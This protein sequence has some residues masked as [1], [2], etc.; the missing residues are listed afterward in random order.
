MGISGSQ[1]ALMFAQGGIARGGATRGGYMSGLVFVTINGQHF[2]FG[3]ETLGGFGILYDTLTVDDILNDAPNTCRF[4]V[5]HKSQ[6]AYITPGM[7]V[8]VQLGSKNNLQ[9]LFAGHI[10]SSRRRVTGQPT[11]APH[12]VEDVNCIDDTW[13]AGFVLVTEQYRGQS[14]TAIAQDLIAKYG[15]PDGFG[16][17]YVQTGLPILDEITFTNEPLSA[18]LMRLAKRAGLSWYIDAYKQVHLFTD[19]TTNGKPSP[20]TPT[21]KTMADF[22]FENDESQ[23]IARVYLEGRGTRVLAD[24]PAGYA[25]IPVEAV[26]MFEVASDV[27]L[28]V[29][30]QGS[31]GGSQ[32]LTFTG[33]SDST[34]G[35]LVGPGVKPSAAPAGTMARGGSIDVGAHQYAYTWVTASGETAPSPIVTLTTGALTTPPTAPTLRNDKETSA[36]DPSQSFIWDR[37]D[38]VQV[39]YSYAMSNS[40]SLDIGMMGPAATI[41]TTGFKYNST[42][43]AAI[44][45]TIVGGMAPYLALWHRVNA[46]TWYCWSPSGFSSPGNGVAR[47]VWLDNPAFHVLG[48]VT[49]P[50]SNPTYQTANLTGIAVG[51]TGVTARKVYRTAAGSSQLKL[52]TTLANNTAT[53]YTDAAADSMLG[54]NA[55][56]NDTSGIVGAEGQV[57]PGSTSM[58]VAST[59][60]ADPSGGWAL[61]G[62]GL[63]FKYYGVSLGSLVG[64]NASG[65]GSLTAAVEY[66][67]TITAAPMLTGVSGLVRPLVA[68]D[69][70]YLVVRADNSWVIQNLAS[71][72]GG[73]GYRDE[74]VQDRRLSITECRQ[75]ASA[76][77]TSRPLGNYTVTYR[78]RDLLT[79]SGKTVDIDFRGHPI[80]LHIPD[81]RIQQVTI[82]NFRPYPRQLPTYQVSATSNRYSFEDLLRRAEYRE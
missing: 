27:T 73:R 74:W 4:S 76:T 36:G 55:P 78:C 37:N 49:P 30:H 14:S 82:S 56:T 7:A 63:A 8:V 44:I 71:Q 2:A 21:H 46:G 57:N 47:D 17:T 31:T 77:L 41:T 40:S 65:P 75:R 64:I 34:G 12:L 45:A 18:C 11:T 20:I 80:G 54:A 16:A 32:L 22:S 72:F 10:L 25:E 58:P 19:E 70:I 79:A 26:D 50:V 81:M 3:N 1:P 48:G 67:A 42:D 38:S 68:G 24:I 28:K 29:S 33:I 59:A 60:W 52:L 62:N 69:E 51:P 15:A 35:S 39:A 5:Y 61:V 43:A 9:R 13:P 23:A 66:G 6:G 53:T